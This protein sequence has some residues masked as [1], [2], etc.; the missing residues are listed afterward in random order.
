MKLHAGNQNLTRWTTVAALAFAVLGTSARAEAIYGYVTRIDSP[1]EFDVGTIHAVMSKNGICILNIGE[2]VRSLCDAKSIAVY[3]N[4]RLIGKARARDKAFVVNKLTIDDF[5]LSPYQ[6]SDGIIL[7]EN[8]IL[9]KGKHGLNRK[10]WMDGYPI[11]ITPQTQVFHEPT[12]TTFSFGYSGAHIIAKAKRHS[13]SLPNLS[14]AAKLRANSCVVFHSV[15]TPNSTITATKLQF[16]P[17]WIDPKEK[18]YDKKFSVAIHLP[19]YSKGIPGT[20]QYQGATPIMILPDK[21]IQDWVTNLGK[22]LIPAYQKNL[23]DS[24][25]TKINFHFYVVHTFPANLGK[26]FVDTSGGFT[27]NYQMLYWDRSSSAFYHRPNGSEIVRTVVVDPNGEILIPDRILDEL[28]N[29]AQLATI[30]SVTITSSI[31][32]QERHAWPRFFPYVTDVLSAINGYWQTQQV[33]R[34]GI[35]QMYLAGYD[36]REAPFAW[37]VARDEVDHNPIQLGRPFKTHFWYAAYA[38]NYISHYYSDVDYSKLK[39]GEREYQQFL[40]ELYKADP[41]LPRPK[42]Q[43]EPQA[44]TRPQAAAQPAAPTISAQPAPVAPSSATPAITQAH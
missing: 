10:I 35:R 29:S 38:F 1:T 8:P 21:A 22:T 16:W 34:L 36:I 4:V 15:R 42:A 32:Q 2:H 11:T 12:D 23:P 30:L 5:A 19:D 39:R 6:M 20:I 3:A 37:A 40:Q 26:Y 31:Q 9:S 13:K 7:E 18:Q 43:L 41:S 27:P 17:N 33:L 44:S 25:A 14:S 28:Q 24:D